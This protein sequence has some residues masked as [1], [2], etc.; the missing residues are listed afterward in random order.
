MLF[1]AGI[2]EQKGQRR[3]YV[4]ITI[5]KFTLTYF[6]SGDLT[7]GCLCRLFGK[8]KMAIHKEEWKSFGFGRKGGESGMGRQ[9]TKR[10]GISE[11]DTGKH[12][13]KKY[14]IINSERYRGWYCGK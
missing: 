9:S 7:D 10:R 12:E 6:C 5:E 14:Y 2:E 3:F 13:T 8:G 1:R 4:Y 11:T